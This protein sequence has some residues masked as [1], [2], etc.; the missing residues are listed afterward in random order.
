MMSLL[1]PKAVEKEMMREMFAT[2]STKEAEKESAGNPRGSGN[3]L[4]RCPAGQLASS[5]WHKS[6]ICF[7]PRHTA[8]YCKDCTRWTTKRSIRMNTTIQEGVSR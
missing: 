6:V 7:E 4:P 8:V 3:E 2:Q 1:W 5:S